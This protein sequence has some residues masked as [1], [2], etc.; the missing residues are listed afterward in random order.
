MVK[1]AI[2]FMEVFNSSIHFIKIHFI[3]RKKNG[4]QLSFR[5]L[6]WFECLRSCKNI[7]NVFGYCQCCV[8]HIL[9]KP[10][11]STATARNQPI[12]IRFSKTHQD[13]TLNPMPQK[14]PKKLPKH[15]AMQVDKGNLVVAIK[16]LSSEEHISLEAAKNWVDAYAASKQNVA[17]KKPNHVQDKGLLDSIKTRVKNEQLIEENKKSGGFARLHDNLDDAIEAQGVSA[18]TYPWW[19]RP[20]VV[21]LIVLVLGT[22]VVWLARRFV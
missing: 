1:V 11:E 8:A 9:G 13:K 5:F 19:V 17:S 16:S 10:Q 18:R 12:Y 14:L 15:I 4:I 22:I 2:L 6:L 7:F 20:L 21:A 3:D